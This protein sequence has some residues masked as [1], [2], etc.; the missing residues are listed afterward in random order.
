[1]KSRNRSSEPLCKNGCIHTCRVKPHQPVADS[2]GPP[3]FQE[4]PHAA[5]AIGEGLKLG[6]LLSQAFRGQLNRRQLSLD[7]ANLTSMG[8]HFTAVERLFAEIGQIEEWCISTLAM[9]TL[10]RAANG[11]PLV[12]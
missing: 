3:P 6:L 2:D 11:A 9:T 7:I 12:P 1:M 5:K 4:L 10:F 8:K